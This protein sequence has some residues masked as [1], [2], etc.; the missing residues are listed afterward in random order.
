[1]KVPKFYI[2]DFL[3]RVS[4]DFLG[5]QTITSQCKDKISA[6]K[7]K[8]FTVETN[9]YHKLVCH[10]DEGASSASIHNAFEFSSSHFF[11]LQH[12]ILLRVL[13][14]PKITTTDDALRKYNPKM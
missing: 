11:D 5:P 1:M 9:D 10:N 4:L 8:T 12:A 6:S 3:S 2:K 14:N 13:V 7:V